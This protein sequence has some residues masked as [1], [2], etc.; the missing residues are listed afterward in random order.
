MVVK[1]ELLKNENNGSIRLAFETNDTEGLEIVDLVRVSMLGN[2]VKRGGYI[3]SNRLVIEV[4]NILAK[5]D[6]INS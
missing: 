3:N 6:E 2:H 5:P 1:V 4:D